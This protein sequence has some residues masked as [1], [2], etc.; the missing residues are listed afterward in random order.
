MEAFKAA[1]LLE[2]HS[3]EA[4]LGYNR[5]LQRVVPPWHFAMMNDVERATAFETAIRATVTQHDLVLDIG[6]GSG[7]LSLMA[8]RCGAQNVVTCEYNP[9]VAAVARRIIELNGY[10][11]QIRVCDKLSSDLCV[12][13]DLPRRADLLTLEVVDCGLLGEGILPTIVHAREHLIT[14]NAMIIPRAATIHAHLLES[15]ELRDRNCVADVTGF[16]LREFNSLSSLEYLP[17]RLSQV[18]HAILTESVEVARFDFLRGDLTPGR[19][20]VCSRSTKSGWC[21]A[22]VFWFSL[23]LAEGITIS[24]DPSNVASHWEQAVQSVRVPF[25]VTMGDVLEFVVAY[26]WRGLVLETVRAHQHLDFA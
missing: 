16:D 24:N 3:A 23:D 25:Q 9:Y 26:D 15:Q 11:P 13:V 5:G 17:A 7:L 1:L 20:K 6:T 2:P 22:V 4:I 19:R 12:G 14:D 18:R 8:A 10:A 21:D